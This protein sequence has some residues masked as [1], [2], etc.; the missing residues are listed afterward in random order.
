MSDH[1]SSLEE[2]EIDFGF[3][4]RVEKK[5]QTSKEAFKV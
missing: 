2:G 1:D 4:D 5:I 3:L